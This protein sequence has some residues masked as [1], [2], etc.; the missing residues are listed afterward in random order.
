MKQIFGY[1]PNTYA[2]GEQYVRFAQA[3]QTEHGEI[4]IHVRNGDGVINSVKLPKDE[5]VKLADALKAT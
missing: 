1:T 4:E 5:A 3:F 2:D